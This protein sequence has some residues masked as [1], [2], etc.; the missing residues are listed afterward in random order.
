MPVAAQPPRP[1]DRRP[2]AC[3]HHR[4]GARITPT[5]T[6]IPPP[7]PPAELHTRRPAGSQAPSAEKKKKTKPFGQTTKTD[8]LTGHLAVRPT[9]EPP[10]RPPSP[11]SAAARTADASPLA[12]G[13]PPPASRTSD[14]RAPTQRRAHPP[15]RRRT[16]HARRLPRPPASRPL[17]LD[18]PLTDSSNAAR[19]QQ[20]P[21][22]ARRDNAAA[23]SGGRHGHQ[24]PRH[25]TPR[26]RQTPPRERQS[27]LEGERRGGKGQQPPRCGPLGRR[28]RRAGGAPL[29]PGA[30][31]DASPGLAHAQR[32]V[33]SV[34]AARG[35]LV[36]VHPL[37]PS[38][39]TSRPT[40][41]HSPGRPVYTR[42]S[43]CYATT[44]G[45]R[46]RA[47]AARSGALTSWLFLSRRPCPCLPP[48]P[49][50]QRAPLS[51][52]SLPPRRPPPA[53]A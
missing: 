19:A 32:S 20:Q 34:H 53:R 22:C 38:P 50:C 52:W 3:A 2:P 13:P 36:V 41:W 49:P 17:T 23:A 28:R 35:G 6:A 27:G 39:W 45:V 43:S 16:P 15:P 21:R 8:T 42:A 7:A 26:R 29:P 47:A 31:A 10:P 24:T 44:T 37:S 30:R 40:V 33:R 18:H 5:T 1:P 14:A 12:I 9:G 46:A 11:T 51:S 48:R 4:R 25:A